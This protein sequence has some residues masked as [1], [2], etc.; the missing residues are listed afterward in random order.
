LISDGK[1]MEKQTNRGKKFRPDYTRP[2]IPALGSILRTGKFS[3]RLAPAPG[4]RYICGSTK[5]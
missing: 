4:V 1:I 2:K 3:D 5:A